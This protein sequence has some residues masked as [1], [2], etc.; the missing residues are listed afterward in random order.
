MPIAAISG[1]D[2]WSMCEGE[3]VTPDAIAQRIADDIRNGHYASGAPLIQ[4]ELAKR[5]GVSRNP[6]REALRLLEARG[7]VTIRGGEGATVRQ[8]SSDD[9][10]E[11]YT[12]RIAL[13]PTIAEAI[14]DG[15]TNRTINRLEDEVEAMAAL[16]DVAEWMRRNY[17]FHIALYELAERPRTAGILTELLSATQP[18]SRRNVDRLG[19]REQADQD[20]RDMVA[21]MRSG[22]A[23]ALG[24]VLVRH[25]EVAVE[26][27]TAEH[28]AD[29]PG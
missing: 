17:A 28:L 12:L 7:V 26:H 19:G 9:L 2:P 11:V 15:C 27:L 13:E 5:F 20:H 3:G 10:D 14:V 22:D 8:L 18:Y 25:L 1:F 6:V 29:R 21:A 4:D 23:A 24:E 16:T